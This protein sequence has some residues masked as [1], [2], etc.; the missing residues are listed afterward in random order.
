MFGWL[1][2][3]RDQQAQVA[4]GWAGVMS[5]PRVLL[6]RSDGQL[7]VQP[8]S[9]LESLRGRHTSL[10][11][12]TISPTAARRLD[13]QGAALEIGAEFLPGQVE[14]FGLKVLC[15]PDGSEHTL[16]S[17]DPGSG[18]LAIDREHSSLDAAVHRE[19]CGTL[20]KLADGESVQLRV[21]IDH[22]VVEV[23][24]NDRMC[25]TTRVYPSRADS[26]GVELF[27]RGGLA[28]LRQLDAWEMGSIWAAD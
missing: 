26:L 27:A 19:P 17:Y 1:W 4:A 6:P 15:A 18:V 5:L 7:G 14:A 3:G 23:Y 22:S 12:V 11:H 8:A 20:L 28:E 13:M 25:L 9:E 21:F 2:E 24:A 16:I 10:S